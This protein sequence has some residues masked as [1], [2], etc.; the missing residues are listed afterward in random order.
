M[1]VVREFFCLQKIVKR[2]T[3]EN[4]WVIYLLIWDNITKV[5]LIPNNIF[6]F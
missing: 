3:G 2:R 6:Y 5:M 1:Q 4:A